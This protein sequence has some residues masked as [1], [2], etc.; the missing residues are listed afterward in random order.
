MSR[1]R[2][3]DQKEVRS[4][5]DDSP[6]AVDSRRSSLASVEQRHGREKRGS[7]ASIEQ[8]YNRDKRSSVPFRRQS[9]PG[10]PRL[11]RDSVQEGF[12]LI[13]EK[14]GQNIRGQLTAICSQVDSIL[15]SY[16][17]DGDLLEHTG[18]EQVEDIEAVNPVAVEFQVKGIA[19]ERDE[20]KSR[21][22][23]LRERIEM[24]TLLADD[25]RE[26]NQH[27]SE[28]IRR[29]DR[30]EALR[31]QLKQSVEAQTDDLAPEPSS[32]PRPLLLPSPPARE[33]GD[34]PFA[35]EALLLQQASPKREDNIAAIAKYKLSTLPS[36][37][38]EAAPVASRP[39]A[40]A[41]VVFDNEVFQRLLTDNP[42]DV[43][44]VQPTI[45]ALIRSVYTPMGGYELQTVASKSQEVSGLDVTVA[46]ANVLEACQFANKLQLE[47]V[48]LP[49]SVDVLS[50]PYSGVKT[51]PDG[52]V[53][54]RG[55]PLGIVVHSGVVTSDFDPTLKRMRYKG[56]DLQVLQRMKEVVRPGETLLSSHVF[57]CAGPALGAEQA[58]VRRVDKLDGCLQ[59]LPAE[60]AHRKFTGLPAAYDVS[61]ASGVTSPTLQPLPPPKPVKKSSLPNGIV[62]FVFLE[63]PDSKK[64]WTADPDAMEDATRILRRISCRL[65]AEHAGVE[66][67]SFRDASKIA[68]FGPADAI[69]FCI[70]LQVELHGVEWPERVM[71]LP[72]CKKK[73]DTAG[74]SVL[75][76]GIRVRA[77]IHRGP[78][79]F[80]ENPTTGDVDYSGPA[81]VIA[82]KLCDVAGGGQTLITEQ[83]LAYAGVP[84]VALSSSRLPSVTFQ[85]L[86]AEYPI[87]ELYP[88]KLAKR[89]MY[90]SELRTPGHWS[91]G[92]A[93]SRRELV[94][95]VDILQKTALLVGCEDLSRETRNDAECAERA[96]EASATGPPG[97][98]PAPFARVSLVFLDVAQSE[99]LWEADFETMGAAVN[100]YKTLV[101]DTA[102]RYRGYM[103]G[104]YKECFSVAFHDEKDA[105]LFALDVQEALP[106]APWPAKLADNTLCREVCC[107][108]TGR[109]LWRGLRVCV[110]C[111]H[112]APICLPHPSTGKVDYWGTNVFKGLSVG[113]L[114][115]GGEVLATASAWYTAQAGVRAGLGPTGEMP[116]VEEF[117]AVL[118]GDIKEPMH[119]IRLTPRK[120]AD[121]SFPAVALESRDRR[122]HWRSSAYAERSRMHTAR[123]IMSRI[124][125]LFS[126][127]IPAILGDELPTI[128]G[129]PVGSVTLLDPLTAPVL[130]PAGRGVAVD[131]KSYLWRG[132]RM[133]IGA[134]CG[135]PT[136]LPDPVSGRMDYWGPMV[137]KSARIAAVATGG[138]VVLSTP[139][140][141]RSKDALEAYGAAIKDL[142]SFELKGISGKTQV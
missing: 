80:V 2:R 111:H 30:T 39:I 41:S 24:L 107:K 57:T 5:S 44:R 106:D 33:T 139:V 94:L 85:G 128:A 16:T 110:G 65:L 78:V 12:D 115:V 90:L 18:R 52:E 31:T 137:N 25:L 126:S 70:E 103:A 15:H 68:F 42:S 124:A 127:G 99:E 117:P 21:V 45:L 87:L 17:E 79:V 114:A 131:G 105:V 86:T 74:A 20:L 136:C 50:N 141:E 133:R 46:F 56:A 64:L 82:A 53:L 100:V 96:L 63:V 142:S 140:Y 134:H 23:S 135:A 97:P 59:M 22:K 120:L 75:W 104:Q 26:Q 54:W 37:P 55:I 76:S 40:F 14:N 48:G 29:K 47:L 113:A 125:S 71:F 92:S 72:G 32:P 66:V 83:T 60:L 35:P 84:T 88:A 13:R 69:A 130:A 38:R 28:E 98:T 89:K 7:I 36:A 118:V 77:A 132:L 1:L 67:R 123:E 51:L 121:R 4:G 91:C 43:L 62:T 73:F 11:H 101:E 95:S 116:L 8:R 112:G 19:D 108:A 9:L 138:Q 27:L 49:W 61:K 129:A 119:L 122:S 34:D 93:E 3:M 6:P 58:V 10:L 81:T 109:R 102:R